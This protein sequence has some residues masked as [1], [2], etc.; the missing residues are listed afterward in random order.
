M[1]YMISSVSKSYS[2]NLEND[3]IKIF[4]IMISNLRDSN[5]TNSKS[6]QNRR[7]HK[8]LKFKKV[9]Y[10][11][12]DPCASYMQSKRSTIWASTPLLL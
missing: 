8:I 7:P 11:G 6:S 3:Q 1:F 5:F 2:S 10:Q 9:E 4:E 12:I